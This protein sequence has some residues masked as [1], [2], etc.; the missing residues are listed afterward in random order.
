M[1]LNSTY[2]KRGCSVRSEWVEFVIG[3]WEYTT[4]REEKEKNNVGKRKCLLAHKSFSLHSLPILTPSPL[5]TFE[6]QS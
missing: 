1:D 4:R 6:S 5:F 3:H 2:L